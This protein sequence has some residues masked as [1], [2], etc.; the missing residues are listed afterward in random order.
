MDVVYRS[1]MVNARA[2]VVFVR[3][4][5]DGTQS[6][7]PGY[8]H[9][10]PQVVTDGQ[11]LDMA[12]IL[13]DLNNQVENFNRRG[14]GF[15]LDRIINFVLCV[16]TY[17]PLHGNTYI[18]TPDWLKKKH[19]VVNVQNNDEKCFMWAVLSALYPVEKN[20]QR[21]SNYVAYEQMLNVQGLEFP[22]PIKLIPHFEK[23]NPTIS[24]NLLYPDSDSNGFCVEYVSKHTDREHHINLLLLDDPEN[25]AKRHYV[26]IKNMSALVCH[27]TNHKTK[28]HVCNYCLHPF[29]SEEVLNRHVTQCM[30]HDPQ[31]VEYPDQNNKKDRTLKFNSRHKQHP[32]PF[33]LVA[34]LESFLTPVQRAETEKSRGLEI[35]DEHVVSGFACHRLTQHAEHEKP[36]FVYSGP[37][38]MTKFYDY[39]MAVAREISRIVRHY[40]DMNPLTREQA[41][42]YDHAVAC[43][44]CGGPFTEQNR[45]VHHHCHISGNCFQHATGAISN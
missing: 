38:A 13:A 18:P 45:K 37:D 12:S 6:W 28:V 5:P 23:H 7:I 9:T 2:D 35:I 22:M 10:R 31:Q 11:P 1:N 30:Q 15:V 39:V 19:C 21:M 40:V 33:F 20:A 43:G 42:D 34:D 41:D 32:L 27:R 16:N 4:H 8:F 14:S 25:P 3:D 26:C 17:R 36:P 24:I 44:N 29:S